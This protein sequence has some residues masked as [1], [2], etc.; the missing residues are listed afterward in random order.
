M[1]LLRLPDLDVLIPTY[2]RPA[3]L[4]VTLA[5]LIA[6]TLPRFR[7]IVSDQSEDGDPTSTPEV[8]AV[9]RVL[10]ARGVQVQLLRHLPRRGLAEHRQFLLDNATAPYV[11]YLDDDLILEPTVLA[12]MLQAIAEE[13]CGFVGSAVHGLSFLHDQRPHEQHIEFWDGPVQPERIEPGGPA[14]RRHRLHNA[15]NLFHLQQRLRATGEIDGAFPRRYKVAWIGACVMYDATMLRAAG[16]FRFWSQ[17]PR[18][19]CGEDVLAQLRVMARHGGCGLLPS[20]VYHQELPT[21][22]TARD[23]DAPFALRLEH[24]APPRATETADQ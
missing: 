2:Q 4:A 12:M 6:Q 7:V 3:A 20:G 17:L 16:G 14:W 18:D 13:R 21:T 9:V 8:Q 5:T 22:V 19:H 11:L 15:S 23:I 1:N 10:R 24:S